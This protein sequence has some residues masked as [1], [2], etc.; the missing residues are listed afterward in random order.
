MT[1]LVSTSDP[2]FLEQ[3]G[4]AITDHGEV[5]VW[6]RY[7]YAAGAENYYFVDSMD[8]FANVLAHQP[9]QTWVR[10]FGEVGLPLRGMVDDEF[11]LQALAVAPDGVEFVVMCLDDLGDHGNCWYACEAG[12]H[13]SELAAALAIHDGERVALGPRPRWYGGAGGIEAY[14]PDQDGIV[15]LGAY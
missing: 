6:L 9:P 3:V 14:I 8:S 1:A 10:V 5:M 15:R 2:I 12:R 13:H 7:A 4:Q 11:I